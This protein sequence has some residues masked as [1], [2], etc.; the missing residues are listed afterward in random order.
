M[1]WE[2]ILTNDVTNTDLIF[3]TEKLRQLNNKNK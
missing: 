3:K 1:D 2:K